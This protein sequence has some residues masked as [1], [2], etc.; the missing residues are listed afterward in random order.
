[1]H[2]E[3][4]HSQAFGG[5]VDYAALYDVCIV[6]AHQMHNEHGFETKW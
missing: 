5:E 6:D 3:K 1:M 2:G 4:D